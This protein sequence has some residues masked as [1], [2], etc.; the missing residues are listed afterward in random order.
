MEAG[1][2]LVEP[3]P[4]NPHVLVIQI[5]R[6]PVNAMSAEIYRALIDTLGAL[7]E[8]RTIR[9]VILTST[10]DRAFIAGADVGQLSQRTVETA[11]SG[12]FLSRRAFGAVRDCAV[13]IVCAV[14][15]AAIGAGMVIASCCDLIVCAE[16]A[17]FAL[18]EVD[19]GV[20]GGTRHVARILPEKIVRMLALTGRRIG[21]DVLERFGAIHAVVPA[22]RLMQTALELASEIAAKSPA[23]VRLMKEAMNLTESMPLP[24]GYRVEQLFTTLATELPDSKEAARAYLEKRRPTFD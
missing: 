13:P 16:N 21:P 14:N 11:L 12:S 7:A 15:G 5:D 17:K 8:Q 2:L 1:R 22:D 4:A 18:P 10:G 9:C 24:E 20:L 6:P 23:I 3:H 19:V